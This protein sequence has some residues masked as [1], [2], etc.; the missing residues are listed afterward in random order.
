MQYYD[1]VSH[2]EMIMSCYM[3]L[4]IIMLL[5]ARIKLRVAA[6]GGDVCLETYHRTTQDC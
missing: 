5:V 4:S 2:L 1:I 6:G 3:Q